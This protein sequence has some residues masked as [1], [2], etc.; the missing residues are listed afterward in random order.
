MNGHPTFAP[1]IGWPLLPVP[2]QQGRLEYP[3]LA[4]SV[5]ESMRVILETRPGEQL[6][7]PEF[8]AG[9]ARLLE[10][11]NTLTTRR[12][13]QDLVAQSLAAWEPRIII[14]SVDVLEVPNE[15]S[16]LR[17]QVA[18]RLQRTGVQQQLGLTLELG[19]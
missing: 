17:I 6:M 2:D 5:R 19:L 12:E 8:G 3:S 9:L 1:R 13:I 15:P 16:H 11:P 4:A 14:D 7:R 10:A 18:Y